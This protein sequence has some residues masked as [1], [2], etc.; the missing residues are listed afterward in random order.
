MPHLS[1]AG[2]AGASTGSISALFY[3]LLTIAMTSSRD[4]NCS[5]NTGFLPTATNRFANWAQRKADRFFGRQPTVLGQSKS[6]HIFKN[7]ELGGYFDYQSYAKF[8]PRAAPRRKVLVRSVAYS[9]SNR[10]RK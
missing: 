9:E 10:I 5:D 1:M 2:R 3:S 6:S 4:L 8:Q 7:R